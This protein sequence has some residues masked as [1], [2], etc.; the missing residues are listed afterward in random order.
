M[1]DYARRRIISDR[2]DRAYDS[3]YDRRDYAYDM[4]DGADYRRG[5]R[6]SGRRDRRDYADNMDSRDYMDG[7]GPE[8]QLTKQ[9]MMEWK[10]N[11]MN[12]DGSMGEHFKF[13]D[14]IE[15]AEK[16]RLR[17]R[18]YSEKDL[19]MTVNMLYSDYCKVLKTVIPPD[20]ELYIYVALADAFLN[21]EDGPEGSEKLALYYKCIVKDA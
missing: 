4:Y 19:C 13:D 10:K 9:E 6:G 5:V 3:M 20:K 1:N 11:L 8:M 14:I 15:V 21:D 12:A 18:G 16:M 17:F 7:H 2:L